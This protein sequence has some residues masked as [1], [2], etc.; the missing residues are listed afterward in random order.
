MKINAKFTHA[1]LLLMPDDG[2]RREI[3]DG[4]LIV[5]PS[6]KLGHQAISL[7]I[8][9]ACLK[10]LETHP[11]EPGL[12]APDLVIE[13]VSPGTAANDRGRN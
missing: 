3:V 9:L 10:Y 13:I 11:I 8:L 1:D 7:R 5:T 4:D 6:P 12:G 2:K